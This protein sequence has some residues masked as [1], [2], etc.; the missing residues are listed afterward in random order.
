MACGLPNGRNNLGFPS[1][2]VL[3]Q[4]E[5]NDEDQRGQSWDTGVSR[6]GFQTAVLP[7]GQQKDT[8]PTAWSY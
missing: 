3:C 6:P 5:D 4:F 8:G 7:L 1:G 2:E